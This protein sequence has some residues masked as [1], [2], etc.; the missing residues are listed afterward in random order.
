MASGGGRV[1]KVLPTTTCSFPDLFLNS[2]SYQIVKYGRQFIQILNK[3]NNILGECC[4]TF[5]L[6]IT[7]I[8]RTVLYVGSSAYAF[9]YAQ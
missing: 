3:Y 7:R 1:V 2:A 9:I 5:E 8:C 6:D 4:Q